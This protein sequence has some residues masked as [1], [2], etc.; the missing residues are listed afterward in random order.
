MLNKKNIRQRETNQQL[1]LKRLLGFNQLDTVHEA[2]DNPELLENVGRLSNKIGL[3]ETI[4]APDSMKTS[5][6]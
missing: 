3:P 5:Q 4:I 6:D 2:T 1:D